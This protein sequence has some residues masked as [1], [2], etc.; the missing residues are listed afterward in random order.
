MVW[1]HKLISIHTHENEIPWKRNLSGLWK[2]NQSSFKVHFLST[3]LPTPFILPQARATF[4]NLVCGWTCRHYYFGSCLASNQQNSFH[5]KFNLFRS[6][7][8]SIYS[9]F[10]KDFHFHC[11]SVYRPWPLAAGSSQSESQ[12][13]AGAGFWRQSRFLTTGS[14]DRACFWPGRQWRNSFDP[15]SKLHSR[16][17][18]TDS[19]TINQM[20]FWHILAHFID[21]LISD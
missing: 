15:S 12:F 16:L 11:L 21:Q 19:S 10:Q 6:R 7:I 2:T 18:E 14:D 4:E 8:R 17:F 20:S 9:A 13:L 3:Y 5:L 1:N